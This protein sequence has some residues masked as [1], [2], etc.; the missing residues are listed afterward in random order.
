VRYVTEKQ[1]IHNH[2]RKLLGSKKILIILDDLWERNPDTLKNLKA[3]L[4]L[5][6]GSMV[7]VIVTTRDE[8]IAREICH[9]VEPYKLDT[10]TVKMCWAIIKQ[11][12]GFK[13]RVDKKQL[14]HIGREIATKCGGVALAAQSL[15]YTLNG[16]TSDE[17]ESVRDNYIWDVSSSKDPSSRNHEVL[18]SLLLSYTHMPE[19]LKLCFSYC[20]VFPKGHLILKYDLIFQWIALGLTEQSSIFDSMQLCEKYITQLLG[21]SFLQYSKTQPLVSLS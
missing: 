5:G 7:T 12:T 19:W 9:S 6:G 17:W 14:K 2:L 8:A 16:K 11:K 18:A 15:G 10:L 21:M 4:R 20:A 13:D 3:M 1:M